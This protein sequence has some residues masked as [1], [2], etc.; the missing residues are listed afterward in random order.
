MK[1][2][3]QGITYL[4]FNFMQTEFILKLWKNFLCHRGFHAF[5]EVWSTKSHYLYCDACEL[6]VHI[7]KIV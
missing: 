7:K 5:D 2:N 6:E 4:L 1:T 3:Y